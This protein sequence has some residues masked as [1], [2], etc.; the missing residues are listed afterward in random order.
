MTVKVASH[1]IDAVYDATQIMSL[2][3]GVLADGDVDDKKAGEMS[4]LLGSAKKA[5]DP[6]IDLLEQL[7]AE[8]NPSHA[9][10]REEVPA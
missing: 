3:A 6:I 10:A 7:Q 1:H 8:Q 2:F 9:Y 4:W 5:L